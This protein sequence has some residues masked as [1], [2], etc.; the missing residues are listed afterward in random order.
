MSN[1]DRGR[2][3]EYAVRDHLRT[4]GYDVIRS[5]GSKTKVDLVAIKTGQVLLVQCKLDGKIS[6]TERTELVRIASAAGGWPIV[7]SRKQGIYLAEI[8]TVTPPKYRKFIID[9][10]E[11]A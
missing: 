11:V 10:M 4:N 8:V 1:Y 3:F 7:A 2:R 5:A 9:E 6:P